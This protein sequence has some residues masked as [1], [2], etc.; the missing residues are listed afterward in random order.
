MNRRFG[1]RWRR[2]P[3]WCLR[4]GEWGEPAR[5]Q[6]EPEAYPAR[7][8]HHGQARLRLAGPLALVAG[9]LALGGCG[10]HLAGHAHALPPDVKV[11]AVP[12]FR[13]QTLTPRLSQM[14]TAAVVRQLLA[15]SSYRIQ[16]RRAG[17]D[18]VLEGTVL[19]LHTT[20][21]TFDPSTGRV[22]TVEVRLELRIRMIDQ[23]TGRAL[24]QADDLVFRDQY[25][26]SAQAQ[27]L[28]EEDTVALRRMSRD[29]AQTVVANILEN[30]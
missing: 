15:Q 11:I 21:V 18:A 7:R 29:A 12:G 9:L 8:R 14:L 16:S 5:P 3:G 27:T 28:F 22:S 2:P 10:Y 1:R 24:Y 23:T 25:Q 20:P 30:F 26:V 17:S 19:S 6:G 13:N 4:R